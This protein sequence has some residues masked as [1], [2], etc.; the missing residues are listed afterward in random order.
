MIRIALA[1]AIAALAVTPAAAQPRGVYSGDF[2]VTTTEP[3]ISID[4]TPRRMRYDDANGRRFTVRAVGPR[5]SRAGATWTSR[6]GA[7]RV[8]LRRATCND[9]MSDRVYRY[10]ARVRIDGH[11]W[12]G[13]ASRAR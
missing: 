2:G 5:I 3:F 8:I 9:G 6:S 7:L 1:A 12:L 13:C 11:E 4:I 10:A